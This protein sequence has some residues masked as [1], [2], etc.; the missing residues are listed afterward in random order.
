MTRKFIRAFALWCVVVISVAAQTDQPMPI[1]RIQNIQF[2]GK[3]DEL[4]WDAIEP[5]PLVQYEPVS[6]SPATERT[7]IRLAY[8]DKYL[9]G[10]FVTPRA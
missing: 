5:L 9:S 2:D 3:V 4:A 1:P 6:G 10:F 7:E 8:D